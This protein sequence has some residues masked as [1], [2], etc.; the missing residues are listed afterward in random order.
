LYN[1]LYS[2]AAN[3][4]IEKYIMAGV[5]NCPSYSCGA[6]SILDAFWLKGDPK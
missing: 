6:K 4:H 3:W 1:Y 2:Y 5:V